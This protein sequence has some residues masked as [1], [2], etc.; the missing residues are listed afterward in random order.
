MI[1][2]ANA[3]VRRKTETNARLDGDAGR[4][5]VAAYFTLVARQAK[6]TRCASQSPVRQ[7]APTTTKVTMKAG[8]AMDNVHAVAAAAKDIL[9][10]CEQR[11]SLES[12][13]RNVF[14]VRR[15]SIA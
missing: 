1:A 11:P 10:H 8:A 7:A 4:S 12:T 5:C 13:R 3:T 15:V 6:V 14:I 9:M 2:A